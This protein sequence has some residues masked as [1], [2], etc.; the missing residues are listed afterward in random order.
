MSHPTASDLILHHYAT[1]PFSEKVRLILGYKRLAWRSVTVPMVLPKPDV[2]ALTGGYR[3]T[4]FLQIGAD[5]YCDSALIARVL[6][7][8]APEPTLY[9]PAS[10]GSAEL[11]SHWADSALFWTAIPYTMQPAGLASIFNNAP[12]EAIKVFGADRA[13]MS[14]HFRRPT[15][16]DGSVQL[17]IYL[18][19]LE[20]QLA[21]GRAFFGGDEVSIADFSVAHPIW[22]IRR[23]PPVAGVLDACPRL[24]AWYERVQALG[25]GQP[26]EKVDAAEALR[27]AASA[28]AGA[29][30]PSAVQAGLGFEAGETVSV[31]ATDYGSDLV[32]GQLVGLSADEVAVRREDERAGAVVV[33][34]PRIGFQI[35]K[36]TP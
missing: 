5:I 22:F 15:V 8:L 28:G 6:E 17:Q 33:H 13:A 35:K 7:R 25:Q 34:F 19:W 18:A 2:V 20:G 3:R 1:S 30:E 12:P 11:L 9:P 27:L 23:A 14:P 31:A 4:P 32:L 16:A 10:A 26:G 29:R 24:A 21:D 36:F